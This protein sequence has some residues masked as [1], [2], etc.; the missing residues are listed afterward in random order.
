MPRRSPRRHDAVAFLVERRRPARQRCAHALRRAPDIARALSRLAPRPRR[1]ARP[2]RRARRARGRARRRRSRSRPPRRICRGELADA[3]DARSASSMPR[4]PS[5]LGG[6]ARR[7]AAADQARRRVRRARATTPSS[8]RRARCATKAAASSPRCRRAMPPRPAAGRCG[9]GTTTCSAISSRCRRRIGEQ[10]LTAPLTATLHPPPDHGGRDALHHR[11]AR[12]AR[13]RRSPPPPS[14][15]SAL[16]LGAV[17]RPGRRR[18]AAGAAEIARRRG[19]ARRARRRGR[20]RRARG[21]ARLDAAAWSTTRLPSTSRAGAIRWSRRRSRRDGRPFVANDCDLGRAEAARGRIWLVT[22]P[23]MAGKS[24][25]LRQNA[26]IAI[27]AQIGSFVPARARAYR[28]RRPAVLAGSAPP[29]ISRAAARPSWSRWSRPR[30]SST[31]PAARSLVILDEIGRGTATFDG[32]SIAWAAIEH[33]HEVNRCRAL[34]ATHYPRADRA[35]RAPAAA[36][37][38]HRAGHGMEGRRGLPARGRAGRGRPLLRHPGGEARRP[39]AGRGRRA[40]ATML[41]RTGGDATRQAPGPRSSTTCRCSRRRAALRR[42]HL[43]PVR[44]R[45]A[46]RSTRST[47]DELTPRE[48]LEALYRL[49]AIGS[50]SPPGEVKSAKPTG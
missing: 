6:G 47:P 42:R 4:W 1:P 20:A 38:R 18:V 12:R 32:L 50:T 30:R 44:T 35:R 41:T 24:T 3:A 34:F 5:A 46:R 48:A 31:R 33:L 27:L 7:R 9:S 22:G 2:R 21:R 16:E 10:L 29:T 40:P 28:R 14:G 19:G 45:S 15:R 37:Q 36:R 26:L 11:R 43:P 8:T 25:F 49:K 23:N 13:G 39:A 17:R